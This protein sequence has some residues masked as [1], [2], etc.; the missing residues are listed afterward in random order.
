MAAMIERARKRLSK[1][2]QKGFRGWPVATVALYGPDDVTA[3]KLT[4]GIVPA[5]DA[6]AIDIRRWFS[7][8]QTDIRDDIR[9]TE[10]VLAF[11]AERIAELSA[12]R[13]HAAGQ[14]FA[15]R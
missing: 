5:E 11:M 1:R 4:V 15:S 14:T 6:E 13:R 10:E 8:E 2:A 7:E 9:V 3:T 12:K